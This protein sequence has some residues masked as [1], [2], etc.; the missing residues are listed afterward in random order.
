MDWIAMLLIPSTIGTRNNSYLN[1]L[2]NHGSTG[3]LIAIQRALKGIIL[4]FTES[5]ADHGS[6][7][8]QR[9]HR[10]AL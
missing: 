7:T 2:E 9:P 1:Y 5:P 6:R 10:P 8:P 3:T 4:L